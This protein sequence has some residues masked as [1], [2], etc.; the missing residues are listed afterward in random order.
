[1]AASVNP[2]VGAA[3]LSPMDTEVELQAVRW[4]AELVGCP[5]GMGRLLV[6][7]GNMANIVGLLAA[8][9]AKAPGDVRADGVRGAPPLAVYASTE[10]HTW[11]QKAADLMGIGTSAIR[12]I[13]VDGEGRMQVD[14]LE[15]AIAADCT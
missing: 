8:R 5:P 6:S 7:G 1:L 11:V 2:N 12:W 3:I 9:R 14:A 13:P 10:S 4:I 15:A